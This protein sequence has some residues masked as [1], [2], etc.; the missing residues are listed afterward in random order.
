MI[1]VSE[2]LNRIF[3]LVSP[4]DTEVV[5]LNSAAGRVL[6]ADLISPR[7]QP[8]FAVS[9]MDGYAVCAE[10]AVPGRRLAVIGVSAAGRPCE[11]AVQPGTAIRIF[12]G[13]EVPKGAD[14]IVIQED[15]RADG[16]IIEVK[17]D[18]DGE[19]YIRPA[20]NDFSIGLQV[21]PPRVLGPATL[22]L[23]ASMNFA[24]VCV[25]KRPEVAIIPSGDE[26]AMPGDPWADGKIIASSGFGVSAILEA[27]GARC[28][29]LPIAEDRLDSIESSFRMAEGSDLIVTIGGA[30][31]GDHDLISAA[32]KRAGLQE[33]FHNVAMRPGKP[34]MAGS[35]AGTPLIGLPGNPVSALVCSYVFLVPALR[36]ILG[37][38]RSPLLRKKAPLADSLPAN[39][40]REHYMRALLAGSE[41]G[42]RLRI[43]ERQDSS[44]VSVM[45]KAN[46][47]A[48][49]PPGSPAKSAGD[50]IEYCEIGLK[51]LVDTNY[52]H[53]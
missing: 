53:S 32:G 33:S 51:S 19:N 41:G 18:L 49:G 8:P 45:A 21:K 47:L 24:A 30:S 6:A 29:I 39:G 27:A 50:L 43:F 44:L 37:F 23:I 11:A 42:E 3:D 48:V 16:K 31:V 20:G 34:V 5:D 1:S 26:L 40:L 13:A 25:R 36:S 12:T 38:G 52:E 22:S 2:A 10:D 4:T 14:R 7:N 17:G 35:I 28:R 46:A 9:A 15:V